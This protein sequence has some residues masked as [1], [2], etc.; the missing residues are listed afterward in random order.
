MGTSCVEMAQVGYESYWINVQLL[1]IA[2]LSKIEKEKERKDER[3]PMKDRKLERGSE[4]VVG[5]QGRQ[6]KM[7]INDEQKRLRE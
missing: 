6:N 5:R 1:V 7:M 4:R 3:E 2:N